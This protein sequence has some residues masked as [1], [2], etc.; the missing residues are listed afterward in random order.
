MTADALAPCAINSSPPVQIVRQFAG[1]IFRCIL[2]NKK[3]CILIK[4]LLQFVSKGPIDNNWVL[5]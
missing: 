2:V 3:F 1:D 5:V 4:N